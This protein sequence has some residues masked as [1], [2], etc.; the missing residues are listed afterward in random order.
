M[1]LFWVVMLYRLMGRY[2]HCRETG[3]LHHS[4][5]LCGGNAVQSSSGIPVHWFRPWSWRQYISL[6]HWYVPVSLHGV[7][8]QNSNIV[9]L[10]IMRT[11]NLTN[12]QMIDEHTLHLSILLTSEIIALHLISYYKTVFWKQVWS[13]VWL[14]L[15]ILYG[16]SHLPE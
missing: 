11:S 7:R 14:I 15:L 5:R 1:L 3:C 6:W 16:S 13:Y 10:T 8:N 12:N 2:H 4:G 9:I